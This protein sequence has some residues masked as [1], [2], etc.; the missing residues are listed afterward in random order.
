MQS[1]PSS[2]TPDPVSRFYPEYDP[3]CGPLPSSRRSATDIPTAAGS[4]DI[5]S[6]LSSV[7]QCGRFGWLPELAKDVSF[8]KP[9]ER[10][11][12]SENNDSQNRSVQQS[13]VPSSLT[14]SLLTQW[15]VVLS[16]RDASATGHSSLLLPH[17]RSPF[18]L[19]DELYL[20][21][22]NVDDSTIQSEDP[23][24]YFR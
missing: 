2:S 20:G 8:P 11:F 3:T 5:S 15:G 14:S 24:A 16:G 22:E 18:S 10:S 13:S 4:T 17:S 9:P 19:V 12:D 6:P 23:S 7:F 1:D 21:D